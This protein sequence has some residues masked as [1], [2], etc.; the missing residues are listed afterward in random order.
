MCVGNCRINPIKLKC[1][2]FAAFLTNIPIITRKHFVLGIS[3]ILHH[4]FNILHRASS[5]SSKCF[6]YHLCTSSAVYAKFFAKGNVLT[7]W[8]HLSTHLQI[9]GSCLPFTVW[10]VRTALVYCQL[11]FLILI[12]ITGKDQL[13]SAFQVKFFFCDNKQDHR[14][15]GR[16]RASC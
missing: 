2:L 13:P 11:S 16:V 10:P 8:T 12:L 6:E 15:Q 5:S 14:G 9:L 7:W 4:L 3:A 1:K